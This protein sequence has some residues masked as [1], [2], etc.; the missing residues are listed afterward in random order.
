M[1]SYQ[2]WTPLERGAVA[3][4]LD[5]YSE[6]MDD[7]RREAPG[8]YDLERAEALAALYERVA[9]SERL[10]LDAADAELIIDAASNALEAELEGD[11][12]YHLRRALDAAGWEVLP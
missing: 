5:A 1:S 2:D 7:M 8:E 6:N 11:E 3:D 10:E 4:A 12:A 9:G